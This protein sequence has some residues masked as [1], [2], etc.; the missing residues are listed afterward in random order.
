MKLAAAFFSFLMTL[1]VHGAFFL[2]LG[3]VTD[4]FHL[5][6]IMEKVYITIL[7][8]LGMLGG[9]VF[10]RRMVYAAIGAFFSF[11]LWALQAKTLFF[12]FKDGIIF[13]SCI[14]FG[15]FVYI[16][17]FMKRRGRK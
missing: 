10:R 15:S 11:F 17:L 7:F 4:S 9:H 16:L 1:V 3:W 6:V 13:I 8:L 2:L 12:A 14:A 5:T